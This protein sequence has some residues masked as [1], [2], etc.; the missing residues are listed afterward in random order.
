ML[1][2]LHKWPKNLSKKLLVA[3]IVGYLNYCGEPVRP[4]DVYWIYLDF[5]P[6]DPPE[7]VSNCI[8]LLR[9]AGHLKRIRRGFYEVTHSGWKYLSYMYLLKQPP[10]PGFMKNVFEY[11]VRYYP[12]YGLE[13]KI[14]DE[15][16]KWSLV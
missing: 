15:D 16:E 8:S 6:S 14:G 12:P 2:P 1:E 4:K 10:L 3:F 7:I 9:R 13:I 5:F 11:V